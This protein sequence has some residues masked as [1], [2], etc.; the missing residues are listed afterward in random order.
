MRVASDRN[1]APID[2]RLHHLIV[3]RETQ[4]TCQLKIAELHR[5]QPRTP[6]G[7]RPAG[8]DRL[9]IQQHLACKIGGTSQRVRPIARK[10]RRANREKLDIEERIAAGH[11]RP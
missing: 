7:P 11:A 2:G 4:R 9:Q 3:V 1:T 8:R 6:I 10:R 5:I